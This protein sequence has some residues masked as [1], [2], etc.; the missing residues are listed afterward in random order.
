MLTLKFIGNHEDSNRFIDLIKRRPSDCVISTRG[1]EIKVHK[2]ILEASSELFKVSYWVISRINLEINYV[3]SQEILKNSGATNAFIVLLEPDPADVNSIVSA[4]Y[5]KSVRI[6]SKNKEKILKLARQL[7]VNIE[8]SSPKQRSDEVSV[9][10]TILRRSPE[11]TIILQPKPKVFS[12]KTLQIP[13]EIS[14]EACSRKDQVPAHSKI[15]KR[16]NAIDVEQNEKEKEKSSKVKETQK[17]VTKKRQTAAAVR[18]PDS[19]Q[20]VPSRRVSVRL[21]SRDSNVA[22]VRRTSIFA[23]NYSNVLR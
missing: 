11:P 23:R 7:K 20:S 5:S 19:P 2:L 15:P 10:A 8:I 13:P 17:V 12:H 21:Q 3:S 18:Q 16:R 14:N 9:P 4:M 22:S 6:D 1:V